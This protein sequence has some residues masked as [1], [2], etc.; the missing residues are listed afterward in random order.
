MHL[1]F[2]VLYF[3]LGHV[4][5]HFSVLLL[6]KKD[7]IKKILLV[8]INFMKG[9]HCDVSIH[10]YNVLLKSNPLIKRN[11]KK[12]NENKIFI[13]QDIIVDLY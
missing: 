9:F 13:L 7:Y 5:F 4:P 12:E 11:D 6:F 1:H 3:C 8:Y 2:S 10:E